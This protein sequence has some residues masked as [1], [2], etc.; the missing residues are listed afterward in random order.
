MEKHLITETGD[1]GHMD[2]NVRNPKPQSEAKDQVKLLLD[3]VSQTHEK[4]KSKDLVNVITGQ[5]NALIKSHRTD[6][7]PFFWQRKWT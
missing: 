6:D 1:G 2:D 4:Y 3:V 5:E 7:K